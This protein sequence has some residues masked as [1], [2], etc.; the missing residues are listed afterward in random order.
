MEKKLP[1]DNSKAVRGASQNSVSQWFENEDTY[2]IAAR[3]GSTQ[4]FHL[5]DNGERK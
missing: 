2:L 1:R 4:Q 5:I 3:N